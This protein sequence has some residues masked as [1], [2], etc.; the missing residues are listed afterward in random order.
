MLWWWLGNLVLL[1]VVI[2]AVVILLLRLETPVVEIRRY[3]Q[4]VRTHGLTTL[5]E[6]DGL[7]E[8]DRTR[9]HATSVRDH[10]SRYADAVKRLA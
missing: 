4:D 1:S 9:A 3:A 7:A 2:P 8:L 10:A 5:D 6:L